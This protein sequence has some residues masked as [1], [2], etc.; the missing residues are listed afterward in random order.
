MHWHSIRNAYQLKDNPYASW[1]S[2][3]SSLT[4]K[5]IVA[6][7]GDFSVRRLQQCW[8]VPQPHEAQRLN[9][10]LRQFA[11]IRE[12]LLLCH[13][14]PWVY[15]RSVIPSQ[16]ASGALRF[17]RTLQHASL[18]AALFK[19]PSLVRSPFEIAE[20]YS[21]DLTGA[22]LSNALGQPLFG[23]RSLF[24]LFNKDLL[25]SEVFLPPCLTHNP[26]F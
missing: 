18:G 21:E 3:D 6:S 25:V 10:K 5:L 20:F 19:Y 24:S 2:D 12:V 7:S 26:S 4:Q 13:G 14:E 17:L 11:L 8:Q 23:R 9:L 22:S 1:L 15:A 16:S